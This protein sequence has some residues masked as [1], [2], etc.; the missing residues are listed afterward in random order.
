LSDDYALTVQEDLQLTQ[1]VFNANSLGVSVGGDF[2]V[3]ADGT[4]NSGTNT[5]AFNGTVDQLFSI[6]GTINNG[7]AGLNNLSVTKSAGALTLEGTQPSLTVLGTFDLTKGTFDDGG[8][9][10][11]VS[12]NITNSGTHLGEGSIHLNGTSTQTIGGDGKGVFENLNLNNTNS[13][14]APISL[15]ANT[16]VNGALTFLQAKHL[17]VDTFNLT[18]GEDAS[19]VGAG[20]DRYI[21]MAGNAGDGGLSMAYSTNSAKTFPVGVENYTPAT[22]GFSSSPSAYGTIT[23]VPVNYE[24][25]TVT[26]NNQSLS[27]FWRV[28]SSGFSDYEGKVTHNFVYNQSDVVGTESGYLPA[29]YYVSDYTWSKGSTSNVNTST[30]VVSDWS[31][32][33]ISADILDGDYTAGSNSAFGTPEKFYSRQ[34]GY[35]NNRNTWSNTSHTGSQASGTPGAGDIV[36]VG[37]G[38]TVTLSSSGYCASLQ[39]AENGVLNVGTYSN[40]DFGMVS[41]HPTEKNGLLRVAAANASGSTFLFP[42]GDFTDFN[43]NLGTT[44]LYTTNSTSGTTYWLPNDVSS[45]G[46]LIISPVGGS[47]II[48]GNTDVTIY[49]DLTTQG[50]SSESWFCPTWNSNYP[51]SPTTRKAKTITIK[52]NFNLEGGALIYYGNNSNAQDFVIHGNLVVDEYAGIQVYSNATNQSIEI[53][54]DLINNASSGWGSNAYAGCDFTDIPVTFFGDTSASV[55]NTAG[56]PTTTFETVTVNKGTSQATTLTIDI[57]GDLDTPTDNWLTLENGTLEY[58]RVNPNSDFTITS[59]SSF[60]IPSTAGLLVDYENDDD[61]DV[62]IANANSNNNDLY[63]NGKLTVNNGN[64]YVGSK[65][66]PAYNNDIEYSGGGASAITVTGGNLVVNGQIR[67]NPSS[68]SG[69]LSYIQ[70]G[71][72]VTINGQNAITTNAKL[73]VLNSGSK[74]NMSGGT[75]T[76]VRGGGGNTYGDLYL[77]PGSSVVTGGDIVFAHDLSGDS[78][79]YLLDATI[80]L[81]NLTITGRTNNTAADATVKL[82]LSALTL[83]GDLTLT[84]ANSLLDANSEFNINLTIKGDLINNGTYNHYSNLTTF[85]GG[86]QTIGGST[87]TDFYDL[88]ISPVTSVE[89]TRSMNVFNDMELASGRLITGTNYVSLKGDLTNNATYESDADQGGVVLE[90]GETQHT[91]SGTGTYGRLE[92]N[93]SNGASLRDNITLQRNLIMTTGVFDINDNLLTLGVNSNIEGS[94]FNVSKMISSDGV[95]SNIGIRKYLPVIGS[96]TVFSFPMGLAG[97]YTPVVLNISQNGQV[98]YVRVNTINEKHPSA[99]S[100]YRVLGYYWEVES[101]AISGFTGSFNMYYDEE[102]VM[103]DASDESS[104]V[105]ARLLVPGTSWSKASSAA[106]NVDE[107]NNII[108]YTFSGV[109]NLSG[110]YTAGLD[111][112]IPDEVPAYEANIA[113]D[114]TNKNIW[115]PVGSAP[116]CPEGGPNGA[117]VI[118]NAE[119]TAN[120]D[121]CFAYRTTINDKLMIVS[122]YIGHNLGAIDGEGTLYVESPVMPAGRYSTFLDCSNSSTL[123]FGGSGDYNIVADLFTSIPNLKISG[124]GSRILPNLDLTI[125]QSLVIDGATLDNSVNNKSLIIQGSMERYNGGVFSAGSGSDATVVFEGDA[126]Q[127]IG[128]ATG[129][130]SGDNA[131]NNL[132]ISNSEGLTVLGGTEV[133]GDLILSN[134]LIHTTSVNPLVITNTSS[135]AVSPSGGSSSS[136]VDGPLTKRINQSNSFVFPVGKEDALGNKIELS[137]TRTGTIDWTVEY[138]APNTT[139]ADFGDPLTYVNSKEYWTV[140]ATAGS[141]AIV[142]LSWDASSDV[143]PL[144]TVNG[145][146]D[147]R[148]ATFNESSSEWN[149]IT[150]G[151][152]GSNS[153]GKVSTSTRVSVPASGDIDFTTATVNTV[154][155]KAK[156]TPTASICGLLEGIPVTFT[157]SEPIAF[158][159]V[160]SYSINGVLQTPATVSALPFVLP[161]PAVGEYEL[162]SF[163]Y[164]NGTGTG[165]VDESIITVNATPTEAD[166]GNDQSLCGATETVLEA[167]TPT[168]GEGVWSIVSGSGGTVVNPTVPNSQFKG[169]NGS[170]YR[171]RWTISNGEC[172]SV[173]EVVVTFPVLAAQPGDFSD[174]DTEVCQ[175]TTDVVYSVPL[176]ETVTYQWTYSGEGVTIDESG[177]SVLL[178]FSASAT[179]G[180]LSV[181]ATNDCNTSAA[182]TIDVT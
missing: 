86:E 92:L 12:G 30:N 137:S 103:Q 167:N 34:S 65:N 104:Y 139:Y 150:S 131:F 135:D 182:R 97:K 122:P 93:D 94:G 175:G 87:A 72:A 105:A 149:E 100:P 125:C 51:S 21:Q 173:D 109:D 120:A 56:T 155:P 134:G 116:D 40:S 89:L 50:Q 48:F 19:I 1:G 10:L 124:T 7:A 146:A 9:T 46:N 163:T 130:F 85:S 17:F 142:G 107:S 118:I 106:D 154:K 63:L 71:G 170:G 176:D 145:L 133:S 114:W 25:P 153:S 171:L 29:V 60:T 172:I 84:N 111:D 69:I 20:E 77:R 178:S 180:T 16:S 68:T 165:V 141:E 24:H 54:G 74:F 57:E 136:Y 23:V 148:V 174:F 88:K 18:L 121:N 159:Y 177:H 119:V 96:A 8:K 95:Y 59:S 13:A 58:K 76:I 98:G 22:F 160:L 36:I 38:H 129:D 11:F 70:S 73:E 14:S 53:G 99:E 61:I 6:D 33:S 156:L 91:L 39:I 35:W 128:G 32:P 4:Y 81:N 126:S 147:L 166:A 161:T 158:N 127:T 115:T 164:N 117:V 108:S 179:G 101:S 5:T 67:R 64:V 168:I 151:A 49:G 66:E 2:T 79:E 140:S 44:E 110:E 47:N 45:Y 123:E 157:T 26:T 113:G 138:F 80:S 28:K 41:N 42:D 181:T 52:G 90:N 144:I 102:D 55:T 78:Q 83:K 162:I 15:I 62:L 37:D 132:E 112:D 169:T 143:T 82:L 3:D 75:L 27:Y 152:A 31:S 43:T